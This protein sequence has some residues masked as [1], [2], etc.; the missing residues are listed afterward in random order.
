VL[1]K[2]WKN[3]VSHICGL[4]EKNGEEKRR[5]LYWRVGRKIDLTPFPVKEWVRF[6][7]VCIEGGH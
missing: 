6:E 3:G 5:Q 1:E 7:E 2:R 4:V